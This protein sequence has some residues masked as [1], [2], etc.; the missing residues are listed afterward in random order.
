MHGLINRVIHRYVR[1]EYGSGFWREIAQR[2]RIDPP[3]FETQHSYPIGVTRRLVGALRRLSG[4]D[5]SVLMRELGRFAVQHPLAVPY[6]Q[7]VQF[8][9]SDYARFLQSLEDVPIRLG[10]V[11][12]DC[13]LPILEVVQMDPQRFYLICKS[14]FEGVGSCVAGMLE[15]MAEIYGC[16]V[17]VSELTHRDC[18][19]SGELLSVRIRTNSSHSGERAGPKTEA[20]SA[21]AWAA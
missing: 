18:A 17:E 3:R 11:L 1:E 16:S 8:G 10:M 15:A 21:R 12:P 6:V 9:G 2:A 19:R 7:L 13:K 4:Q 5:T 14:D 20:W